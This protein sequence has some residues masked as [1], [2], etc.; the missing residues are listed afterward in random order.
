MKRKRTFGLTVAPKADQHGPSHMSYMSRMSAAQRIVSM[1][2]TSAELDACELAATMLR[3]GGVS[4]EDTLSDLLPGTPW[5]RQVGLMKLVLAIIED[6]GWVR[7]GGQ[8]SKAGTWM[9][10][11]D[12]TGGR[13]IARAA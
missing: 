4:A 3:W 6:E 1:Q 5:K 9:R 7:T 10:V 13:G 8:D 11:E 12:Q 2:V